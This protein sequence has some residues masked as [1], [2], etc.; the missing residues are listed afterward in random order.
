MNLVSFAKQK[1][2]FTSSNQTLAVWRS[3]FTVER[4]TEERMVQW[5]SQLI[6]D[7]NKT[8]NCGNDITNLTKLMVMDTRIQIVKEGSSRK[9][10]TIRIR[11]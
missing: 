1:E 11:Q 9:K 4:S 2:F 7:I 10:Y 5:R 8:I 6:S 3:P